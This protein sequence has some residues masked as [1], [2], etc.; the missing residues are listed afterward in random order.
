[1]NQNSSYVVPNYPQLNEK[2]EDLNKPRNMP[3][4][5][6]MPNKNNFNVEQTKHLLF[7]SNYCNHSKTLLGEL[8]KR[9]VL[10]SLE[11]ICIDNRF[12]KEKITY[13][14]LNNNQNMPLPPMINSVPTLCILPNHEILKGKQILGYF[15]PVSKNIQQEREKINLEPNPFS[16]GGETIGQYGVS[17]DNF[18]FWDSNSDELSASGDGGTR[19]MYNYVSINDG[20]KN[21]S[22]YTPSEEIK[23][24]KMKMTLEQLQQQRQQEI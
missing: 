22:I 1:M 13:I 8:N 18:S 14:C 21:D 20:N 2:K 5:Q 12:L 15:N 7:F 16:I 11:L 24:N 17:S 10:D 23:E 9:N 3:N 4:Q 19:Q 6:M